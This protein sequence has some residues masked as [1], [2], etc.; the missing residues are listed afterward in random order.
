M[1]YNKEL[2]DRLFLQREEQRTHVEYRQEFGFYSIV[3]EGNM[4][5]VKKVLVDPSNTGLYERD[6]YGKLSKAPLMNMRYHF[7]VSVSLITRLCA[8]KGLEREL[9]Y[10]LSDIY[11]S[12]MD[13]LN[14][15]RDIIALHN[16]MLMDFTRK[17]AELPKNKVCSIHVR[18]SMEYIYRHLH[19]RLTAEDIAAELGINR[20]YLSTVFKK[21]T[22]I[23]IGEFIRRE[24]ISAAENM[25]KFSDYSCAEIGEYFG[26]ASQSHFISCFKEVTGVTPKEYRKQLTVL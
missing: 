6:E 24:K 14:D 17:M 20:C 1:S 4:E 15:P 11:I 12:K 2:N 3:T 8:E 26:F 23:A 25:L 22:G 7:V 16:E 10:T 21:E 5:A 9:A 18:R 19:G 13:M